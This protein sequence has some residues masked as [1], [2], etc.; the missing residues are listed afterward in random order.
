MIQ[1]VNDSI[2]P[3]LYVTPLPIW[4]IETRFSD[5]KIGEEKKMS[6]NRHEESL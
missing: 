5:F 4:A 2:L 6:I 1:W 3:V